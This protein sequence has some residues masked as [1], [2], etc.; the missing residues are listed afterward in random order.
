M[1]NTNMTPTRAPATMARGA[2]LVVAH[3][4]MKKA[5]WMQKGETIE[6]PYYGTSM[7][8]CGS[9][10]RTLTAPADNPA[11]A[12]VVNGYL[13]VQHQLRADVL[14]AESIEALK[15]MADELPADRYSSLRDVTAKLAQ[16]KDLSSARVAFKA[17]SAELIRAVAQSGK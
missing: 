7:S 2:T 8:T 15:T 17:E 12:A 3:C 11:L 14:D 9:V 13:T 4:P 5:D 16:A 10:T 1:S 6:N